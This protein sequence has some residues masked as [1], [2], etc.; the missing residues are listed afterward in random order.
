[1][2]AW[3]KM[4]IS[5][6]VSVIASLASLTAGAADFAAPWF[7]HGL[8]GPIFSNKTVDKNVETRNYESALWASTIVLGKMC[9]PIK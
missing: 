5:F 7:Y 8:E 9:M 6:I 1:M 4:E 3:Q 2:R